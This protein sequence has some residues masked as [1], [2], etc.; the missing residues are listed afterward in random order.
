MIKR[1]RFSKEQIVGILKEH[2]VGP[3]AKDACR[4]HGIG[5]AAFSKWRLRRGGRE[6][7]NARRLKARRI[8]RFGWAGALRWN[9]DCAFCRQGRPRCR[10]PKA[11]G[12]RP[13]HPHDPVRPCPG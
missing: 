12:S 1:C 10:S 9:R 3:G 7:P 13:A 5:D 6:V 11:E 2:Q 4:K 8:D